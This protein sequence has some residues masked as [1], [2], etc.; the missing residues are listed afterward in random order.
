MSWRRKPLVA[1]THRP[2]SAGHGRKQGSPPGET[3]SGPTIPLQESL[4]MPACPLDDDSCKSRLSAFGRQEFA[5]E[6]GQ[7]RS[8]QENKGWDVL[9]RIGRNGRNE[10]KG[11]YGMIDERE[12]KRNGKKKELNKKTNGWI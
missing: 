2:P 12:M 11:M 1:T 8:A 3:G 4:L 5:A 6:L 10:R 9:T 7:S